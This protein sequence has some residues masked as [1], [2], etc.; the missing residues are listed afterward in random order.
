MNILMSNIED[1]NLHK[2]EN[3]SLSHVLLEPDIIFFC[4]FVETILA[5]FNEK[6]DGDRIDLCFDD[7]VIAKYDGIPCE[8]FNITL[9]REGYELEKGYTSNYHF[10]EIENFRCLWIDLYYSKE[11]YNS[12]KVFKDIIREINNF[13]NRD[14]KKYL[15]TL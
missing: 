8:A 13:K 11:D 10:S 5:Y 12:D 3:L 2:Y 6:R 9:Y 15:D 7:G 4:E 14:F 1:K